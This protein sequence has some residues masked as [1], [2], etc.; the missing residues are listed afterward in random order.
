[1]TVLPILE[2]NEQPTLSY[3][4][5]IPATRFSPNYKLS[6]IAQRNKLYMPLTHATYPL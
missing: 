3:I 6:F 1:M 5:I 2:Q 4:N